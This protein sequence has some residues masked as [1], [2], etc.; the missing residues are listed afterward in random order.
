LTDTPS[1]NGSIR[2]E[3]LF[4]LYLL[5]SHRCLRSNRGFHSDKLNSLFRKKFGKDAKKSLQWLL[6]ERLIC[7]MGKS[8]PKYY[9]CDIK[10]AFFT[11]SE[12]GYNVTKGR[13]RLL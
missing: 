9:I 5:Y 8:P 4:I 1:R 2:S 6:N 12:N 7:R 13:E 11:L 3:E 10:R